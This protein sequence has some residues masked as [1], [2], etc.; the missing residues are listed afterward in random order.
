M[1][2]TARTAT[3]LRTLHADMSKYG[4]RLVVELGQLNDGDTFRAIDITGNEF[5]AMMCGH[6][7]KGGKWKTR[8]EMRDCAPI[9]LGERLSKS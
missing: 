5:P 8:P 7:G 2:I 1:A 9:W 3:K 4:Y 6:P